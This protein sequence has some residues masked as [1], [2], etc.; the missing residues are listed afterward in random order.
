ADAAPTTY[1]GALI[2]GP[3]GATYTLLRGVDAGSQRTRARVQSTV[4]EGSLDSVFQA[5]NDGAKDVEANAREDEEPVPVVLGEGLAER[6]G[7][8]RVGDEG[9]VLTG[10]V[11]QG[12]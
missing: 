12:S 2:S 5:A 4:T 6:T 7:L 10:N 11:A 3:E 9:W 8:V 1:E